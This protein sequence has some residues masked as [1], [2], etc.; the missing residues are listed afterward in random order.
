MADRVAIFNEGKIVQ[1]GA[2][3]D[4]YERPR[5]HFVADFVGSSN[6]LP[7]AFAAAHGGIA[8][9]TSLRPEKISVSSPGAAVP[10]SHGS[11]DGVVKTIS[12]QGSVTRFGIEVSDLRLHA[13]VPAT[14]TSLKQGDS[15]RIHWPR[16]AMV[17]MEGD[18]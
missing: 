11:A 5:S 1:V 17:A 2:P 13:D 7:P 16:S 4:V 6:V 12:Y 18:A 3:A 9:W 10:D 14:S 8:K 15:V